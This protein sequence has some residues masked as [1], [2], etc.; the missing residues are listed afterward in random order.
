M[1]NS[2]LSKSNVQQPPT[3]QGNQMCHGQKNTPKASSDNSPSQHTPIV[4]QTIQDLPHATANT[5]LMKTRTQ[6]HRQSVL[7]SDSD[8]GSNNH[9]TKSENTE[10]NMFVVEAIIGHEIDAT[11]SFVECN[12]YVTY[13]FNRIT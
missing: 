9:Q 8:N 4:I 1:V 11:V 13:I 10:D 12:S 3:H 5:H 2:P 7:S 6:K